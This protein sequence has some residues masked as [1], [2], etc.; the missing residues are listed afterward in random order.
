MLQNYG[1]Q[2]LTIKSHPDRIQTSAQTQ[3]KCDSY[4]Q[5]NKSKYL[6]DRRSD[7]PSNHDFRFSK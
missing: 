5:Q 1:S 2:Y 3:T 6:R 4:S 7:R